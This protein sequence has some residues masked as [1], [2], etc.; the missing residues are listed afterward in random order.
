MMT[1]TEFY[2]TFFK[3]DDNY[4]IAERHLKLIDECVKSGTKLVVGSSYPLRKTYP[5]LETAKALHEGK[6]VLI[7]GRGPGSYNAMLAQLENYQIDFKI[8][9]KDSKSITIAAR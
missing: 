4:Q 1:F 3:G 9:A 5:V 2:N 8:I 7:A 6:T